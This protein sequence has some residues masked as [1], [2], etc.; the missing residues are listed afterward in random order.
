MASGHLAYNALYFFFYFPNPNLPLC[1]ACWCL[2]SLQRSKSFLNFHLGLRI[3]IMVWADDQF[4]RSLLVLCCVQLHL[5]F[6]L[7]WVS[8]NTTQVFYFVFKKSLESFYIPCFVLC[9][10]VV[11]HCHSCVCVIYR[12][13]C[14][15]T[16]NCE[17][18]IT[19]FLTL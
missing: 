12:F 13:G 2:S 16:E 8:G 5:Y 15:L 7:C 19:V 4:A 9:S 11:E 10:A 17:C 14:V 6:C 18:L 1:T 3:L